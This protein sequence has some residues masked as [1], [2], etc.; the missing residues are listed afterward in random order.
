MKFA[1]KIEQDLVTKKFKTTKYYI[2]PICGYMT[3]TSE[4][5]GK[6]T[7]EFGEEDFILF[8]FASLTTSKGTTKEYCACP[9]CDALQVIDGCE[10][11]E[12]DVFVPKDQDGYVS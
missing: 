12:L 8:P 1:K 10:A 9:A 11:S 7:R 6:I 2:C 3:I 4:F 5:D